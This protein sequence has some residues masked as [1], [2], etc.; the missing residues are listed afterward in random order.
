MIKAN[1]DLV[2]DLIDKR[3]ELHQYPETA[4]EE[5]E[6]T[7]KLK[8]WLKEAGISIVKPELKTGVIAEVEG[9]KPGPTIAI[10]SDIDAL[11]VKEA[12]GL[13]FASKI[14][15]K[16]HACGHDFHMASIL[17]TAMLLEKHKAELKGKVRFIFQP[18]EENAEG[19][20]WMTAQGALE[21]V[22]A[23]FGMHNKPDL[24]VG[25]IGIKSGALM[26]SVDRFHLVFKGVGGHAGI[27]HETVDPIVIASQYVNAAQSI[28]ARKISLFQNAVLSITHIE[29]GSTWNVIPDSVMLEGT[30]RTF[31]EEARE[32]VEQWMRKLAYA[33][34]EGEGGEAEF[35]WMKKMPTIQNDPI[36]Q[37]VLEQTARELDYNPV[38]GKPSSGG[39]DFAFYQQHIPGF[40]VWMGT[41]GTKQWH[42]PEFNLDES[43]IK[44]ASEYFANLAVNV[45]EDAALLIAE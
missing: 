14:P 29:G 37:S 15:G 39:E 16:M 7:K 38:E 21:G 20:E 3:R 11:P 28:I 8:R 30:V 19:A 32:Q 5:I 6:T 2:K 13:P 45:L 1:E 22:S 12:T 33:T 10:R 34:A 40:F 9:E 24:P 27:P 43:A 23:I 26:A 4:F 25:T 31:Q 18:A 42:H 44:V 35:Q 41:N 17:G 36:F